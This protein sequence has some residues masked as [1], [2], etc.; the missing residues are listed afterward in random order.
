MLGITRQFHTQD[1]KLP[2]LEATTCRVIS[3]PQS[4][5][6]VMQRLAGS[7]GAA[8]PLMAAGLLMV[9]PHCLTL[10]SLS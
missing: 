8:G 3:E 9:E 6:P 1:G 4:S 7:C 2:S 10:S 5:L